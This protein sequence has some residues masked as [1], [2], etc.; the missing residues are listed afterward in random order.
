VAMPG[1]PE[2]PLSF[3]SPEQTVRAQLFGVCDSAMSV[4]RALRQHTMSLELLCVV[5]R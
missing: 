4:F 5:G 1:A 2:M 3:V